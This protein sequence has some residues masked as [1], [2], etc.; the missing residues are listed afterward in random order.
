MMTQV[1]WAGETGGRS[2]S[3]TDWFPRTALGE[4]LK[5]YRWVV[6]ESFV[7]EHAAFLSYIRGAPA[8]VA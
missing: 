7:A 8:R 6:I 3:K 5:S 4:K 2:Q 1:V